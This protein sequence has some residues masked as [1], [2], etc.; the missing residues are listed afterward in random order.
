L[1]HYTDLVIKSDWQ[2]SLS[3]KEDVKVTML[4]ECTLKE[5]GVKC[6]FVSPDVNWWAEKNYWYFV[7]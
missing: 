5:E 7:D 1:F 2:K 6:V 4:L 3:R